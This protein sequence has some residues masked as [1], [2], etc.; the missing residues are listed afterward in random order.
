[1][2]S[3]SGLYFA[4]LVRAQTI[5]QTHD[6]VIHTNMPHEYYRLILHKPGNPVLLLPIE[7]LMQHGNKHFKA[8]CDGKTMPQLAVAD[9]FEA[10]PDP[11]DEEHIAIA[12]GALQSDDDEQAPMIVV[13]APAIPL[14]IGAAALHMSLTSQS[15]KPFVVYE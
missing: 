14:E 6:I 9:A 2:V 12:D 13:D 5:W 3:R 11:H 7:E 4:V 10:D 8:I 15:W 1:M